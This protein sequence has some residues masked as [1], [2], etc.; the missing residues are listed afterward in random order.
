M[1]IR[2]DQHVQKTAEFMQQNIPASKLVAVAKAMNEL[3][4]ILWK[5]FSSEDIQAVRLEAD[6][7]T[8][9]SQPVATG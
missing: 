1:Q 6:P 9:E 5:Q 4:P 8:R 3:G 2:I 7:I